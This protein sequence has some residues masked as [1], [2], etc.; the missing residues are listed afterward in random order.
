MTASCYCQVPLFFKGS[1]E[2]DLAA[3]DDSY[4]N[5][6]SLFSKH[7]IRNSNIETNLITTAS[8]Y[9]HARMP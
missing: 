4:D 3:Y 1:L 5:L 8:G 6:L 9:C 2:K 7:E